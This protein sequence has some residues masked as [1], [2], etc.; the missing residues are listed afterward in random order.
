MH[1]YAGPVEPLADEIKPADQATS[2][3]TAASPQAAQPTG[4]SPQQ[5]ASE[6]A[7]KGVITASDDDKAKFRC[8]GFG[9][10]SKTEKKRKP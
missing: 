9:G 1:V 10:R 6:S 7:P 2:A 8:C 5:V 4:A 3:S